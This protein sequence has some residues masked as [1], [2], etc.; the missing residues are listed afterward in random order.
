LQYFSFIYLILQLNIFIF[1][2]LNPDKVEIENNLFY[3]QVKTFHIFRYRIELH[4]LLNEYKYYQYHLYCNIK[5]LY[6]YNLNC[7]KNILL[8]IRLLP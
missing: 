5:N 6:E 4:H 8:L 1:D 3:F 2:N 7:T